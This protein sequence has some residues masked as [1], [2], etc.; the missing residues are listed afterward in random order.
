MLHCVLTLELIYFVYLF[1][2]F[3]EDLIGITHK[4]TAHSE[5]STK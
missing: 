1:I 4:K 2:L 5:G 3:Y